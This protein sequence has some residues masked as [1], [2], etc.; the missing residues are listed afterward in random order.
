[1]CLPDLM[2]ICISYV[3]NDSQMKNVSDWLKKALAT[4]LKLSVCPV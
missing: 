2:L 4:V 1:M 3:E